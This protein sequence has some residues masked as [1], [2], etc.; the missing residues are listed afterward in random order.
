MIDK[1]SYISIKKENDNFNNKLSNNIKNKEISLINEECYLI[2]ESWS[3]ELNECFEKHNKLKNEKKNT[4]KINYINY[5]PQNDPEFI[6][7][8]SSI[9]KYLNNNKKIKLVSKKLI[10]SIYED[11]DLIE[12]EI[13][14][15]Y[16]GNNKLIIEYKEN[17]KTNKPLL[18]INPL[19]DN[20]IKKKLFIIL[21][22]EEE[23]D[24][25]YKEL[26][27]AQDNDGVLQ[28]Y[29]KKL[30]SYDKY[31]NILKLLIH[32]YY[33]EKSLSENKE[34]VFKENEDIYLINPKWIEELKKYYD[35]DNFFESF[36]EQKNENNNKI[37]YNNLS[38]FF[39][40]I[41]NYRNNINFKEKELFDDLKSIKAEKIKY[42]NIEYY[43][44]CYIINSEIMN[45]ITVIDKFI[46]H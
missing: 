3:N 37:N 13:I 21:V 33:Y 22:K 44:N 9:I 38:E 24:S 29:N 18:L 11:E 23:K 39:N 16:S 4:S 43:H 10:E 26:L 42:N 40:N 6:N 32:I 28:K 15:Y 12:N 8:F 1:K 19:D 17:N 14:N 20:D 45:L 35:F 5:L 25:L 2:E 30:I 41:V 46:Q 7:D 36:N 31:L 34:N 27:S